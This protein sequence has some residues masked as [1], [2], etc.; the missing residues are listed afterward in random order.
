MAISVET[1]AKESLKL[2][3]KLQQLVDSGL[4]ERDA[5]V[6]LLPKD[7]NRRR[8]LKGWKNKGL[9]PIPDSERADDSTTVNTTSTTAAKSTSPPPQTALPDTPTATTVSSG[10]SE[11]TIEPHPQTALP[12]VFDTTDLDSSDERQI[13][14]WN[15]INERV[16]QCVDQTLEARLKAL[17]AG[18]HV[19][20]KPPAGPGKQYKGGKTHTKINVSI[21]TEL[22]DALKSLG[23]V[24]S[25][26]VSNAIE[27][28]LTLRNSTTDTT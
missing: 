19:S 10:Y 5:L 15:F 3:L 16:T 7:T 27:L 8:L 1:Q 13:K 26:H 24:T 14:L 11:P 12:V 6:K 17:T 23:G 25:Q 18:F 21:P 2:R 22:H 9:F 20:E 4:S 28:Y